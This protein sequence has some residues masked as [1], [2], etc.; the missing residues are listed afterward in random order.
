[1]SD[2]ILLAQTILAQRNEDVEKWMNVLFVVVLAA[3]WALGGILKA[4]TKKRQS[5]D[6]AQPLR[7]PAPR[8]PV[9]SRAAQERGLQAPQRPAVRKEPPPH[10]L[11]RT[12]LAEWRA[13]AQKFA[14]EAEQAFRVQIQQSAQTPERPAQ[15]PESPPESP[16]V[17]QP[18]E[19]P[20][21]TRNAV[22]LSP[23]EETLPSAYLPDLLSDY[24]DPDQLRRAILHY[25]ILGKPLALREPPDSL[26]G[27]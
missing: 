18:S 5:R 9:Q 6:A 26:I 11:P 2:L 19:I 4:R 8:P 14:T 25:E 24:T 16:D 27:P 17:L 20:S 23:S 3:F 21:T 15:R 10:R 13:A 22:K 7:S 12:R 1:M